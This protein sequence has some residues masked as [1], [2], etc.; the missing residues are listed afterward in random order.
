MGKLRIS[1]GQGVEGFPLFV[2]GQ[3]GTAIVVGMEM[4][5]EQQ[6]AV[7]L[8]MGDL[9]RLDS[10]CAAGHLVVEVP[11]VGGATIEG[12]RLV[13]SWSGANAS[14]KL[15]PSHGQTTLHRTVLA[16]E[17]ADEAACIAAWLDQEAARLRV[18]SCAGEL[19]SRVPRLPRFVPSE[20]RGRAGRGR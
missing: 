14:V 2:L 11:D 8:W 4:E 16:R 12:G 19:A 9:Y 6:I 1:Q 13:D 10:L 7:E 3:E 18:I 17:A 20:T 15:F 5:I